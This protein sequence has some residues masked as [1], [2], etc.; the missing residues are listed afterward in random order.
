MRQ[1][2]QVTSAD[3]KAFTDFHL[4]EFNDSNKPTVAHSHFPAMFSAI[5]TSVTSPT[6]TA[7]SRRQIRAAQF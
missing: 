2:G 6:Q 1:N 7:S 4:R 3:H 5:P